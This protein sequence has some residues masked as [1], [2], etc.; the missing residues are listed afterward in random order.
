VLDSGCS[1]HMTDN[2]N[3]FTTLG[4]PGDHEHVTFGDN[5][6]A[7]IISLGRIVITNDLSI[8]NVQFVESLSFNLLSVAQLCDLRLICTFDKYGV[9]LFHEKDKSLVFNDFRYGHFYIIYYSFYDA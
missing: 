3:M 4:D 1:Q 5:S 7:R 2:D 6:W 9:I 8:S